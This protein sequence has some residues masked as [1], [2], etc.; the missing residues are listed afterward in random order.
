MKTNKTKL[1]SRKSVW[2]IYFFENY[3]LR[4]SQQSIETAKNHNCDRS[5]FYKYHFYFA[6]NYNKNVATAKRNSFKLVL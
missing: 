1:N 3:G 5:K 2:K 6:K 4:A